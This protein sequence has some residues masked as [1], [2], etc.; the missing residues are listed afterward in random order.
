MTIG[1]FFDLTIGDIM[2]KDTLTTTE[3]VR[4]TEIA[5]KMAEL[6]V[7]AVAVVNS[8]GG[9][10]GIL[11]ERDMMTEILAKDIDSS[12]V[13]V[14]EVM[15]PNPKIFKP[16]TAVPK[17]FRRMHDGNFRHAPVVD[18]GKLVG[19]VSIKDVDE[20][21]LKTLEEILF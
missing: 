7:G 14:G 4:V 12:K 11:T 3:E 8:E 2:S 21:I 1:N 9:L 6:N 10:T 18:A 20:A 5:K 15:T 19:M 13:T 16:S 17:V